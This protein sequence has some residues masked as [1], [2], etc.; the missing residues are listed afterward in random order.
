MADDSWQ[1]ILSQELS[2]PLQEPVPLAIVPR[3]S[4]LHELTQFSEYTEDVQQVCFNKS[5]ALSIP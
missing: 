4:T 2:V 3:T 1:R 5:N